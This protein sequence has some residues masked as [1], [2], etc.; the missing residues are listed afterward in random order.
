MLWRLCQTVS[1]S[2]W[3]W[4]PSSSKIVLSV[5]PSSNDGSSVTSGW[6]ENEYLLWCLQLTRCSLFSSDNSHLILSRVMLSFSPSI[7]GPTTLVSSSIKGVM[8]C[9][10][11]LLFTLLRTWISLNACDATALTLSWTRLI[12]TFLTPFS[13]CSPGCLFSTES[14]SRSSVNWAT[15]PT[16]V[17]IPFSVNTRGILWEKILPSRLAPVSIATCSPIS[18]LRF[19]EVVDISMP[20]TDLLTAPPAAPA[21]APTAAPTAAWARAC[22]HVTFSPSP[23]FLPA[24]V[25]RDVAAPPTAPLA[26]PIPTYC[27]IVREADSIAALPRPA[28]A[29]VMPTAAPAVAAPPTN[30]IPAFFSHCLLSNSSTTDV[31]LTV[32]CKD[33]SP[34]PKKP[35][36]N[37]PPAATATGA[38]NPAV[39]IVTPMPTNV[40]PSDAANVINL[41]L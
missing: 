9:W 4:T 38:A 5:A 31:L 28:T 37:T 11:C 7:R 32:C 23:N 27:P 21:A 33:C 8:S 36:P 24:S 12:A 20:T 2:D 22:F 25:A 34:A 15:E 18:P 29:A 3:S 1:L 41:C 10:E 26:A 17:A 6:L 13:T 30:P 16:T 39:P 40:I 19:A 35:P 14:S